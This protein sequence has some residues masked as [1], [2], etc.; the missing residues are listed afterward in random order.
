MTDRGAGVLA[1]SQP[2]TVDSLENTLARL[3]TSAADANPATT[4]VVD[5][6]PF[7]APFK[8]I[9]PDEEEYDGIV[10][11]ACRCAV[12]HRTPPQGRFSAR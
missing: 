12:R 5:P 4:G 6:Q 11:T 9:G 3:R 8:P 2:W 7:G 1:N 10:P